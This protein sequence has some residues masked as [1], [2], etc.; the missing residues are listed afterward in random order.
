MEIE[1]H[2]HSPENCGNPASGGAKSGA[3][4]P[5]KSAIDDDLAALIDAWPT[6][7]DPIRVAIR[8]LLGT[9]PGPLSR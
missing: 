4:A 8:A 9:V 6:L 2:A 5:G 7:P 3:P 1:P